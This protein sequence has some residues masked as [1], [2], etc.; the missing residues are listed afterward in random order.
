MDRITQLSTIERIAKP[1]LESQGYQLAERELVMDG[2][3][4]IL[5]IYIDKEGGVTLEDCSEV[6][7][8]LSAHLDVEDPIP[9]RY[10]LEISSPGIERPL[11]YPGDF[12][13]FAGETIQLKTIEP[14]DGRQNYRGTLVKSDAKNIVM[15]VD[16]REFVIPFSALARARIVKDWAKEK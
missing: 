4:L 10:D 16:G 15:N 5:R 6:S 7:R 3:R 12:E 14:I 9:G 2:G 13:R 1:V 11:R 8:S